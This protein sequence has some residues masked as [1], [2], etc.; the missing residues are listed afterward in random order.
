MFNFLKI[1]RTGAPKFVPASF[2]DRNEKPVNPGRGW[3]H[4]YTFQLEKKD[5]NELEWLPYYENETLALLLIDIGAYR[6]GPIDGDA[7]IYFENIIKKFRR[8][9]KEIILRIVYDREGKGLE[10]EPSLFSRVKGHMLQLGKIVKRHLDDIYISQG[11]FVGSWGEM[12]SSKFLSANGLKELAG[13][14]NEAAGGVGMAFRKPAQIRSAVGGS[15]NFD[16]YMR[17]G[18]KMIGL[19]D[20]AILALG[21]HLGTFAES[22]EKGGKKPGW[23]EPWGR[24]DEFKFIRTIAAAAPCGGEAVANGALPSPDEAVGVLKG[25]RI[26][27]LNCV[28]DEK[29]IRYWKSCAPFCGWENLYEYIGA[30]MGYRM[31]VAGVGARADGRHGPY[32]KI[33]IENRGFA[34]MYFDAGLFAAVERRDGTCFEEEV[35]GF[36]IAG[37]DGGRRAE[38]LVRGSAFFEPSGRIY[39]S[40]KRKSDGRA[41]EFVGGAQGRLF[42]GETT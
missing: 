6:D 40:I 38:A 10:K 26:S 42:L 39:L 35:K 34:R 20:D 7:L 13:T 8:E 4:I 9:G 23:D 30:H 29:M 3:Y 33:I 15:E 25:M 24:D 21:G 12:H 11:V 41:V 18:G 16:E 19:F 2:G 27:Y 1:G 31:A 28:H 37:L 22:V 5:E 17:S 32:L 36:D 14:W